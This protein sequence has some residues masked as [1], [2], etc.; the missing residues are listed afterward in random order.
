MIK[1]KSILWG[2]DNHVCIFQR[3]IDL[4]GKVFEVYVKADGLCSGLKLD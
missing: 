3:A 2:N 4:M 1:H